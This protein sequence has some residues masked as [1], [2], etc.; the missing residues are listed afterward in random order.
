MQETTPKNKNKEKLHLWATKNIDRHS[1]VWVALIFLKTKHS[2]DSGQSNGH[3]EKRSS[4]RKFI[5]LG[6]LNVKVTPP[7]VFRVSEQLN[8]IDCM[9]FFNRKDDSSV[10]A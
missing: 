5:L 1:M 6:K 2:F 4:S 10:D 7:Q 8:I 3:N 9:L